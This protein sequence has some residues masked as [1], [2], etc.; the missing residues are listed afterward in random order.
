V[1]IFV[2]ETWKELNQA[3][4]ALS[5]AGQ[6]QVRTAAIACI[7]HLKEKCPNP[8]IFNTPCPHP[9][10]DSLLPI[11]ETQSGLQLCNCRNYNLLIAWGSEKP[12]VGLVNAVTHDEEL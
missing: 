2:V 1:Y 5:E 11:L 12:I 9:D 4:F 7:A 8:K 3:Y 10:C 6:E